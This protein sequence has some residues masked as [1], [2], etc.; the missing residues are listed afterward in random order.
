MRWNSG[1]GNT[2]KQ[3]SCPLVITTL[4][5]SSSRNFAGRISRPLSS[6][7]GVW[8]PRNTTPTPLSREVRSPPGRAEPSAP[9]LAPPLLH[10]PPPSTRNDPAGSHVR[11]KT[12]CS[13]GVGSGGAGGTGAACRW[14][15]RHRL[16]GVAVLINRLLGSET[17]RSDGRSGGMWGRY[18][19]VEDV[20][21]IV[22]ST[23][24]SRRRYGACGHAR[25]PDADAVGR[26]RHDRVRPPAE[27]VSAPP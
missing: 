27:P 20:A 16:P 1:I 23:G 21:K 24:V 10:F 25:T 9:P 18:G 26:S 12:S 7:R 15:F 13:A 5:A 19:S 2:Y 11:A 17:S 8:V 6:R 3:R 14:P 4:P 22:D